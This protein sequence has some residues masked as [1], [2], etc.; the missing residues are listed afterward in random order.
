M[1]ENSTRVVEPPR[2]VLM[3]SDVGLPT[4]YGPLCA[5]IKEDGARRPRDASFV[6]KR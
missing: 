2:C 1:S 4:T 6:T 5:V 3:V